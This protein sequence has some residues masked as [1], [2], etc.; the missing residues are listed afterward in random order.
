[1]GCNFCGSLAPKKFVGWIIL[2]FGTLPFFFKLE[3]SSDQSDK[4]C[5]MGFLRLNHLKFQDCKVG[6]RIGKMFGCDEFSSWVLVPWISSTSSIS[7]LGL[8]GA[9]WKC[10]PKTLLPYVTWVFDVVLATPSSSSLEFDT[11]NVETINFGVG[12][13]QLG[14]H[15]IQGYPYLLRVLLV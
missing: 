6:R 3:V 5:F 13:Q 12:C 8:V 10:A 9:C 15:Q 7:S 11:I 2:G 1:V 14:Q 4:V